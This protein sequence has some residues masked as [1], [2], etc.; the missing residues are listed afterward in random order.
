MMSDLLFLVTMVGVALIL[1]APPRSRR[2][3]VTLAVLLA[4]IAT[5]A[6]IGWIRGWQL[7][8]GI[9]S[10]TTLFMLGGFAVFVEPARR[11]G[12]AKV[13]SVDTST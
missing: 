6:L 13:K 12:S 2:A 1:F 5:W 7:S 4:G 11:R 8:A 10:F 9:A 3:W